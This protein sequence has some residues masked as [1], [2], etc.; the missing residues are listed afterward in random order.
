MSTSLTFDFFAGS[1]MGTSFVHGTYAGTAPT[2]LQY[3]F[4]NN[5]TSTQT[6]W[7][8]C[9]YM[10]TTSFAANEYGAIVI[11]PP[12]VCNSG[13][14]L[15]R[16]TASPSIVTSNNLTGPVGPAEGIMPFRDMFKA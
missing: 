4:V 10:D 7:F 16:V 8:D 5:D 14:I 3:S 11:G 15:L 2:A 6:A 13:T 9:P 1:M 12:F